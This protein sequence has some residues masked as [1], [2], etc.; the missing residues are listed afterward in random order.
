MQELRKKL[1]G[2]GSINSTLREWSQG[3]VGRK[4]FQEVTEEFAAIVDYL[5]KN[6]PPSGNGTAP[7]AAQRPRSL[8]DQAGAN[9]KQVVDEAAAARGRTTGPG[10]W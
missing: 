2:V 9:D 1:R 5:A 10:S 7:A 6:L 4:T 3:I 8:I